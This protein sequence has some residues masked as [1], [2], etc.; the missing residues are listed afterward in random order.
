MLKK[1]IMILGKKKEILFLKN[2]KKKDVQIIKTDKIIKI[3][4]FEK[5][6]KLIK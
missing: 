5:S 3:T 6:L 4:S 2:R 1:I